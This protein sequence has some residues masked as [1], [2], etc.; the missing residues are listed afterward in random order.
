MEEQAIQS[1]GCPE[2][3]AACTT[4]SEQHADVSL[5]VKVKPYAVL[6]EVTT[7][8]CG[9]PVVTVKQSCGCIGCEITITQSLCIS[10]P[11]E[12]GASV[13]AGEIA[14]VCKRTPGGGCTPCR[15]LP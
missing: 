11:V 8:C 9:E 4:V 2:D 3:A 1:C 5:P 7:D 14:V 15:T 12:Y 13:E 10:I 6:G